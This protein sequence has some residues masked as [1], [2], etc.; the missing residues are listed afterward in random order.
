MSI[1]I[2]KNFTFFIAINLLILICKFYPYL[3][4]RVCSRDPSGVVLLNFLIRN[5]YR[6]HQWVFRGVFLRGDFRTPL[7]H[8]SREST[9]WCLHLGRIHKRST[10]IYFHNTRKIIKSSICQMELLVLKFF[11]MLFH[12]PEDQ[13]II[14]LFF[15]PPNTQHYKSNNNHHRSSC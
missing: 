12:T 10:T 11:L 2:F 7:A 1:I 5:T 4:A 8:S 6:S 15:V 3:R 14:F 13:S 9:L